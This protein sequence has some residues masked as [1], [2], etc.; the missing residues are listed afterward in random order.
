VVIED[1]DRMNKISTEKMSGL[2]G[3]SA[4]QLIA[5]SIGFVAL[6]VGAR[7][8]VSDDLLSF[9]SSIDYYGFEP[10]PDECASLNKKDGHPWKSTTFI[11][12]A[13]GSSEGSMDL[14]IYRQRGC[15]S[16][17]EAC[18][19]IGE[20]FSRGDYYILDGVIQVPTMT[21]DHSVGEYFIDSPAFMK[22]DVQGMEVDVFQG[23][24]RTLTNSLVGIRTEVNFFPTYKGQPLFAEIDQALRPYGFVP[25]R[26]LESHEWRRLTRIKY[27]ALADG[28]LPYSRGQMMHAD[29]LYLLHPESLKADT[30]A[31]V[32]RLVKLAL[33]AVCYEHFDHAYAVFKRPQVREY[34]M[35]G[36]KIDPLAV[37]VD[38]SAEYAIRGKQTRL[39]KYRRLVSQI[40]NRFTGA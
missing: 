24:I 17:L 19:D 6:D 30:E 3:Y 18:R 11:P 10:D 7:R 26:W 1:L 20:M 21:L 28:D 23:G 14:N 22:I 35:R 9:A 39:Q 4:L 15:S 16:G 13:L 12:A 37:I 27:P 36:F 32:E 2:K 31:D 40:K 25:M 8:G 5:G 33:S 29:I 38:I 34:I